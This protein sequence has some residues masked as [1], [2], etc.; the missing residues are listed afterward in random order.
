ME[1][2]SVQKPERIWQQFRPHILISLMGSAPPTAK[3]R[4]CCTGFRKK[5]ACGNPQD[6]SLSCGFHVDSA[7]GLT[8]LNGAKSASNIA[9]YGVKICSRNPGTLARIFRGYEMHFCYQTI[10]RGHAAL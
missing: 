8:T 9:V 7:L 6:V 4:I 1:A 10:S 3:C 2:K 5:T